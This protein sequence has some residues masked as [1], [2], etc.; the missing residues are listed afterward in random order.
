MFPALVGRFLTS[1]PPGKSCLYSYCHYE[2][3][4]RTICLYEVDLNPGNEG[5]GSLWWW[6]ESGE[7]DASLVWG[8]RGLPFLSLG[9]GFPLCQMH[10]FAEITPYRPFPGQIDTLW[11]APNTSACFLSRTCTAQELLPSLRV[12]IQSSPKSAKFVY[13][14]PT[15][16]PPAWPSA[17][18]KV[19]GQQFW[20][21]W[22]NE[23]QLSEWVAP[24]TP[25]VWASLVSCS[26]NI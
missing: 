4:C 24:M 8:Y 10:V 11:D 12:L 13:G 20:G 25:E 15:H 1:G 7:Q 22:M 14:S 19:H 21:G 6:W 5:E 17:R 23:L 16:Q 2:A 26:V 9:L 3:V 18:H